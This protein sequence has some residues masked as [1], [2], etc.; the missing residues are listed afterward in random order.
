MQRKVDRLAAS[1]AAY[2]HAAE[3]TLTADS[4]YEFRVVGGCGP[5]PHVAIFVAAPVDVDVDIP[6]CPDFEMACTSVAF[7]MMLSEIALQI[8]CGR[9]SVSPRLFIAFMSL[10]AAVTGENP[11]PVG[12]VVARIASAF[13]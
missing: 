13:Y 1:A 7:N 8:A 12:T 2:L 10:D 11:V 6:V 5:G 3:K 9:C 4:S